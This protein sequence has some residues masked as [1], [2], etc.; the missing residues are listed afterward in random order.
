MNGTGRRRQDR[1]QKTGQAGEADKSKTCV[2]VLKIT[3]KAQIL[4][5]FKDLLN[6]LFYGYYCYPACMSVCHVCT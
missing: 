5:I 3:N 2:K 1:L 6:L 4:F